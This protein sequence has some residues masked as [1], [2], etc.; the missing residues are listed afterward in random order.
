MLY[1]TFLLVLISVIEL[2]V[3]VHVRSDSKYIY[4]NK[5]QHLVRLLMLKS[6]VGNEKITWKQNNN[7]IRY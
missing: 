2:N 1:F 3:H 4:T 6:Q 7:K 5:Y